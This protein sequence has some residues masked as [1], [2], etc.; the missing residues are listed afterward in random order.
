MVP[1]QGGSK[2]RR[3]ADL[4]HLQRLA[5][6]VVGEQGLI[7]WVS[8][9]STDPMPQPGHLYETTLTRHSLRLLLRPSTD[10]KVCDLRVLL[11]HKHMLLVP[12]R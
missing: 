12:G 8:V 11:N 5:S 3:V 9:R 1:L 2:E 10:V 4:F 7:H 6:E